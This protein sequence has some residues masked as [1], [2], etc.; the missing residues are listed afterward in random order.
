MV[1]PIPDTTLRSGRAYLA[2]RAPD[3]LVVVPVATGA[4]HQQ[5]FVL[6]MGVP[7]L[8]H[9]QEAERIQPRTVVLLVNHLLLFFSVPINT[10]NTIVSTQYRPGVISSI[11]TCT[12]N[13]RIFLSCSGDPFPTRH[14]EH[15]EGEW[16]WHKRTKRP[17]A[18]T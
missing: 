2:D 15:P 8:Q 5:R 3:L 13:R 6:L 17:R 14:E 11:I 1:R 4:S 18:G 10:E 7:R 12:S 9:L 16:Q